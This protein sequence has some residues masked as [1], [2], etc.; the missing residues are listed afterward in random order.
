MAAK[1]LIEA[2]TYTTT[3]SEVADEAAALAKVNSSITGLNLNGVTATVDGGIFLAPIAGTAAN[4]NGT[5]GSYTFIVTLNKGAGT[6]QTME[7]LTLTIAA[8]PY[9]QTPQGPPTETELALEKAL[10]NLNTSVPTPDF[11]TLAGEWTV[12]ALARGGYSNPEYY[13]AYYGRV[14]AAIADKA[15]GGSLEDGKLSESKST[16]NSRAILG[17]T[18][19]GVD[20]TNV[21]GVDLVAPLADMEWVANQGANGSIFALLALDSGGY[22][23]AVPRETYVEAI[24]DAEIAGGGWSLGG[25]EPDPDIT[26]MALQALAPY[27]LEAVAD[28]PEGQ[29]QNEIVT[30]VN[31]ALDWLSSEQQEDGTFLSNFGTTP[32]KSS[33]S[34]AQVIVALSTLGIDANSD[35]RFVK[36]DISAVDALLSFADESGGFKHTTDGTLNGMATD[37]ATYALVAYDRFKKG[38]KPLYDMSDVAP[39]ITEGENAAATAAIASIAAAKT[40][41]ESATYTASQSDI[42]SEASA[43]AKV[44]EIIANMKLNGVTATVGEASYTPAIAG[45]ASNANGTNGSYT[46]TVTL[47]KGEGAERTTSTLTLTITATPYSAPVDKPYIPDI[48]PP[49][50]RDTAPDTVSSLLSASISVKPQTWTGKALKPVPTVAFSGKALANGRD[51]KVSYKNNVKIGKATLT[52]TGTGAYKDARTATFNIVP[53]KLT[54]LK[55]TPGK[56]LLNVRFKKSTKAQD[57]TGYQIR[58]KAA[59]AKKWTVKTYKVKSKAAG[60]LTKQIKELKSGKAYNVQARAYKKIT[61]GVSKGTYYGDW[62]KA[63]TKRTK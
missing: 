57:V 17:L 47:N 22:E 56:K 19:I 62:T 31:A 30:A 4:A 63:K 12:I 46:F 48:T 36:N 61:T 29:T 42:T 14:L 21:G 37:Q 24:L 45:T 49:I 25:V 32:E 60:T 15:E 33:E 41:V 10:T 7:P 8:T 53:K 5:N 38:E 52:I 6:P 59:N 3:Q 27:Y 34:L 44:N 40:L 35:E 18:A 55:L 13:D 23:S 1:D 54:S 16:E 58:Y 2:A 39:L 50:Y 20:A 9:E 43:R 51:Y 11:G 28:D 26:A